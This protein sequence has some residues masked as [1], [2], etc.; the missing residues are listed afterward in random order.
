M[1]QAGV[2]SPHLTPHLGNVGSYQDVQTQSKQKRCPVKLNCPQ[3]IKN[4]MASS[5]NFKE[6]AFWHDESNRQRNKS[7]EELRQKSNFRHEELHNN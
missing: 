5:W 3:G 1:N 6:K 7:T 2:H 4:T